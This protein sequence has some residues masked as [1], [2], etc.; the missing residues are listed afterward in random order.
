M[1]RGWK[2][3]SSRTSRGCGNST[4]D[5]TDDVGVDPPCGISNIALP[6]PLYFMQEIDGVCLDFSG[7][8][9]N[10]NIRMKQDFG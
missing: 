10:G 3:V 5:W 8:Q 7:P 9:A 6:L 4:T 1:V 2:D